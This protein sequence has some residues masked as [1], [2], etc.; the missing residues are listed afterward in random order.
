MHGTDGIS[1]QADA[2]SPVNLSLKE[3]RAFGLPAYFLD[4]GEALVY[5]D[6]KIFEAEELESFADDGEPDPLP[7]VVLE[8]GVGIEYGWRHACP[9]Q[10][11]LCAREATGRLDEAA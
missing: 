6:E 1:V 11:P 7:A 10:C 8:T 5:R 2:L 4:Y 3:V 9:C